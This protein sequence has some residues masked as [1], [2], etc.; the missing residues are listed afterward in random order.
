MEELTFFKR[1]VPYSVGVRFHMRD[2]V[3]KTLTQNDPYV[4]VTEQQL[5]DFK[6]A[7]REHIEA[8]LILETK[9]PDLDSETPNAITDEQAQALVKNVFGLKKVLKEVTSEAPV[10]KLLEEAKLQKRPEKTIKLIKDR[11]YE[12]TGGDPSEMQGTSWDRPPKE[13][14]LY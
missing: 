3:G 9:E 5:R 13:D 2:R 11:L 1:N 8:G 10:L 4:A 7:N 12:I 14:V 6:R